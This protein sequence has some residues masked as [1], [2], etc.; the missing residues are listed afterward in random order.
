MNSFAPVI[1][2]VDLPLVLVARRDIGVADVQD[3]L[4]KARN[5][6]G[7]LN[8]AFPVPARRTT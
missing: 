1:I 7:G 8:Y 3:L 4:Q 5:T 6:P 2:L